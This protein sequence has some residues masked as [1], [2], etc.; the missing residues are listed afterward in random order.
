LATQEEKFHLKIVDGLADSRV[1]LV[2]LSQE[3]SGE[4]LPIQ[5]RFLKYFANYI[6]TM[7]GKKI[8]PFH[9]GNHQKLCQAIKLGFDEIGLTELVK[10]PIIPTNE[11]LD[12]P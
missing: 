8:I 10:E 2:M 3:M 6:N 4:S 5:D 1:S 9:M 11:Y 7:A 12:I